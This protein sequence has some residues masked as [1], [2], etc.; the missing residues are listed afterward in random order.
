MEHGTVFTYN[1]REIS[2]VI[3]LDLQLRHTLTNHKSRARQ[4]KIQGNKLITRQCI[5]NWMAYTYIRGNR[6]KLIL[7]LMALSDVSYNK[8]GQTEARK[9]LLEKKKKHCGEKVQEIWVGTVARTS[10]G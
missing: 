4:A 7:Q 2:D 8:C 9:D 6:M 1:Q 5:W 3:Q 10:R